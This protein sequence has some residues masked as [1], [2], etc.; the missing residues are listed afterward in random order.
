M[1]GLFAG[2]FSFEVLNGSVLEGRSR[3]LGGLFLSAVWILL[4]H[5]EKSRKTEERTGSGS[6]KPS[7]LFSIINVN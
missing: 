2:D 7:P 3:F 1:D 5:R 6:S 4:R